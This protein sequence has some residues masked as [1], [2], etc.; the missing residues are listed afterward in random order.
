MNKHLSSSHHF[1]SNI[2]DVKVHGPDYKNMDREEALDDFLQRIGHYKNIYETM[3]EEHEGD[4]SF[5]KI[6][7][8]GEKLIVN[9]HEGNLQ[10][11]IVYWLMNIHITPRTIYLTRHGESMHN[12]VGK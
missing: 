3:L 4:L 5:M 11:R 1:Q 10:S 6:V 2:L 9:R 12:V 7:N 8:A